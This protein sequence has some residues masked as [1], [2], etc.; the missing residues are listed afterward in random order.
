[1]NSPSP[2]FMGT[3][4]GTVLSLAPYVASQDIVRTVVL[5]LIGAVV[6]FTVSVLLKRYY[7]E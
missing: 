5:A 2:L 7:R 4:G 1:M 3:A 6:S